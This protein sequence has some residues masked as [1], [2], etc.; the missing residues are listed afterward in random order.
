VAPESCLRR[1]YRASDSASSSHR[2]RRGSRTPKV[3]VGSVRH[4]PYTDLSPVGHRRCGTCKE[5]CRGVFARRQLLVGCDNQ[6]ASEFI[7]SQRRYRSPMQLRINAGWRQKWRLSKRRHGAARPKRE[8]ASL[9]CG[10]VMR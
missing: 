3:G 8:S 7:L 6:R 4:L 10:Q 5:V 1:R 9:G 2:N